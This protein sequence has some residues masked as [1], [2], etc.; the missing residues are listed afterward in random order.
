MLTDLVSPTQVP[1]VVPT[2]SGT[3]FTVAGGARVGS[4]GYATAAQ[5]N[6]PQAVAVDALGNIYIADRN[7]HVVRMVTK[8]TGIISTVAGNRVAGYS[9]DGGQAISARLNFPQGVAADISGNIYIAD[10]VNKRI[11]HVTKSINAFVW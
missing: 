1:T 2:S 8:S 4:R 6:G 5:F 11:C 10:D 7:N 3:I 9:G